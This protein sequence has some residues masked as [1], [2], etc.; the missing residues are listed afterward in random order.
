MKRSC[1]KDS[2]NVFKKSHVITL[3]DAVQQGDYDMAHTIIIN[4]CDID[5]QDG[6]GNTALHYATFK[7]D[8]EMS[9]LLIEY[10]ANIHIKNWLGRLPIHHVAMT[11]D[12]ELFEY[13]G[14]YNSGSQEMDHD[15]MTCFDFACLHGRTEI[16]KYLVEEVLTYPSMVYA[17]KGDYNEIIE[18][19]LSKDAKPDI[20]CIY[21]V[22]FN[23]NVEIFSKVI[24]K[25]EDVNGTYHGK[26]ILQMI[27]TMGSPIMKRYLDER[28]WDLQHMDNMTEIF[29]N[30]SL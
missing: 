25:F 15:G 2:S 23:R 17:C 30:T 8:P 7:N 26:T 29:H 1:T 4:G 10:G 22:I 28:I 11:G 12:V 9:G 6:S 14:S 19:L 20:R 13:L 27:D 5:H 18:Y 3:I 24:K 16:V 21:Y